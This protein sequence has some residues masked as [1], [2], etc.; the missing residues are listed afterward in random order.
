M[1]KTSI[2]YKGA[3]S[4][5]ELK[6]VLEDLI[7]GLD[8]GTIY[9]Q[10]GNEVAA[11]SPSDVIDMS[12]KAGQKKSEAKLS[13]ELNWRIGLKDVAPED[14]IKITDT[15]PVIETPEPEAAAEEKEETEEKEEA[16]EKKD[17]P[18]PEAKAEEAE[19]PV[20]KNEPAKPAAKPAAKAAAK[21]AK[22]AAKGAAKK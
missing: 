17:E 1:G 22:P 18:K 7:K 16:Q 14:M 5:K 13:L 4:P 21:P 9:L 8:K 12:L 6:A 19:K 10:Q 2:S 11:L 3:I 20:E 15:E